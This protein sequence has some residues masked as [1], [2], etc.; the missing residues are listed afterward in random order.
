MGRSS[1]KVFMFGSSIVTNLLL[2]YALPVLFA[3]FQNIGKFLEL[4]FLAFLL[5]SGTLKNFAKVFKVI[6]FASALFY[7]NQ[8]KSINTISGPKLDNNQ[9]LYCSQAVYLGD[10]LS[11]IRN[12]QEAHKLG[13]HGGVCGCV[14]WN[15]LFFI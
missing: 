12:A 4:R 6:V 11:R 3:V 9:I 10:A 14:G 1:N 8:F 2:A 15:Y 7:H 13:R 5:R